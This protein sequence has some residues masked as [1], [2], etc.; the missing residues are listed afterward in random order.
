MGFDKHG[1]VFISGFT[2]VF[3]ELPLQVKSRLSTELR[4]LA[5]LDLFHFARLRRKWIA[6]LYEL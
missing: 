3:L 6:V 4:L 1:A 5:A 2:G